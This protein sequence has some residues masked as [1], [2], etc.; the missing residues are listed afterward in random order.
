MN[1]EDHLRRERAIQVAIKTSS[2][3]QQMNCG[4]DDA[5]NAFLYVAS[6]IYSG[7]R[8]GAKGMTQICETRDIVH[9]RLKNYF[10]SLPNTQS[11]AKIE[12]QLSDMGFKGGE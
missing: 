12:Q 9:E 5:I 1:A 2:A 6:M 8:S 3:M 7:E 11:D 10:A 4:P